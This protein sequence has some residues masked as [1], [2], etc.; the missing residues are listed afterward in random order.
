METAPK[1]DGL[2]G[3]LTR[4]SF[5]EYVEETLKRMEERET[6]ASLGLIDL[7]MFKAFND[8][9]GHLIG[10]E[11]LKSMAEIIGKN[12]REGDLL[13]RYGGDEF[14]LYLPDTNAEIA[15]ILLEEIRKLVYDTEFI[16]KVQEK[17]VKTRFTLSIGISTFPRDAK[18]ITELF[19][20]GDEA[21]YR[22]KVEGRNRVCLALP[23]ERMK[24]KTTFYTAKQME[25]LAMVAKETKKSESFLLREALDDLI[26]KYT[27]LKETENTLLELQI[28]RGLIDLVDPAKG[29]LLLQEIPLIREE[30]KKDFNV[31]LPGVRFRDNL[32]LK[33]LEY[34]IKFRG[35]E[36]ERRE[37]EEFNNKTK[38]EIAA[39]LREIFKNNITRL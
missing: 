29:G 5:M 10:D 23:E 32:D 8:R 16:L 39:H 38:D 25:R 6:Y 37:I 28:G 4:A 20:K 24:S 27:D 22:A 33:T 18:N 21:L 13:C 26:K 36:I 14:V 19:R 30:I 11:L 3:L 35:E 17:I 7:D 1:K 9:E 34:I 15:L 2:T 31:I 12:T